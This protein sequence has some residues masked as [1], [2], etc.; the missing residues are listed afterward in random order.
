MINNKKYERPEGR[1]RLDIICYTMY[2]L[3]NP[4]HKLYFIGSPNNVSA[5]MSDN[6][7]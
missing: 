1:N 3:K 2:S 6:Q 5:K 4:L 7:N